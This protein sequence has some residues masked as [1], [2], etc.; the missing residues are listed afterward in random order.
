MGATL[1]P[2]D[3]DGIGESA[4]PPAC[5]SGG[6]ASEVKDGFKFIVR[7]WLAG[8]GELL[9]SANDAVDCEVIEAV[10]PGGAESPNRSI[11]E[12]SL[13][14]PGEGG[15]ASVEIETEVSTLGKSVAELLSGNTAMGVFSLT[16]ADTLVE[17]SSLWRPSDAS[18]RSAYFL[19]MLYVHDATYLDPVQQRLIT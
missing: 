10:L 2:G 4:V 19:S 15:V 12:D 18:S 11:V 14:M 7:C 16:G 1:F 13:A 8:C 5:D 17:A 3:T 9:C 6:L